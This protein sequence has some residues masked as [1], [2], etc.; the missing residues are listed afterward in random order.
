MNDDEEEDEENWNGGEADEENTNELVLLLLLKG[1]IFS[2]HR[3]IRTI[4][5]TIARATPAINQY[6]EHPP[7][8][9]FLRGGGNRGLSE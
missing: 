5:A 7:V 3:T 6:T 8:E 1:V 2:S 9:S 4:A